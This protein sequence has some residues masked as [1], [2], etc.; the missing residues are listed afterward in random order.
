MNR[1]RQQGFGSKPV[2]VLFGLC[3]LLGAFAYFSGVPAYYD[4]QVQ[5]KVAEVF[6]SADV[7]RAEIKQFVEKNSASALNATP[8]ACDGGVASGVKISP[9]LKSIAV[10]RVGAITATLD[11]RSLPELSP[12]TNVLTWVPLIDA[13]HALGIGDASKTIFAWRC[14]GP[15]D[16]TTIPARY[17]PSDCRG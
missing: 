15:Q 2:V 16:G 9:H 4:Y 8:F 1:N 10:S 17:L 5:K 3:A 6:V 13:T 14:G 12:A 11:Y 7:C